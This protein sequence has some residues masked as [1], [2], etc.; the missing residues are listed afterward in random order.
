MKRKICVVTGTRADY[1]LLKEIIKLISRDPDLELQLVATGSHLSPDHGLTYREIEGDGFQLDRK[2]E[3]L[4]SSDSPS[5]T[6]KSLGLCLIGFGDVF[7]ELR[8]DLLVVLGDRYEILG[9][10]TAAL[11]AK[12]PVAHVHG[13]ELTEGAYDD[14]LRHSITKMSHLH[15]VAAPAYRNRVI[16]LGEQPQYVH[17]VGGL[18]VDSLK[19]L[20]LLDR[21]ELERSLNYRFAKKNLL[22]TFHPVTLSDQSDQQQLREL[23][24]ALG[25][26]KD[27]NFIFTLPNADTGS[28]ALK[29]IIEDFVLNHENAR[30]YAS[31]G[32][33][34]YLSCMAMVDGV[35]GNSSSGLLEA[36]TLGKGSVNIGDRQKGRLTA[37]SVINSKP[38]ED[39]IK[40]AINKLF[41]TEFQNSLAE[42]KNPYGNG[43]ASE[44]IL[45]VIKATNLNALPS[46]TFYNLE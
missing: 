10:V 40:E 42:V 46:K 27:I 11:F 24:K 26:F 41:S 31:L 28:R 30:A 34:R 36:P 9:A 43:G 21:A 7:A 17:N 35:V 45:G 20:K 44:K 1:G 15:F 23:L 8:P 39:D 33:L 14:A 32:Q 18:G 3:M 16:Q 22:V 29:A 25:S 38:N 4:T 5:G 13:G 6:A 37:S 12:I 19:K 2:V